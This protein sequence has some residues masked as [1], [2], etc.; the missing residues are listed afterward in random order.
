M[1]EQNVQRTVSL[2]IFLPNN[3]QEKERLVGKVNM[4]MQT[5]S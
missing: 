5:H 2:L 3:S 1:N 4:K